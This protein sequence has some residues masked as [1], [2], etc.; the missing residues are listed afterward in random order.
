MSY[1]TTDT[2]TMKREIVNFSNKL[3]HDLPKPNKKFIADM[4]YGILASKS[5][6]LSDITDTLHEDIKKKNTIERLS[7][8]LANGTPDLLLDH[9]LT[10][11][12]KWI[13]D[14]PVIHID[15][16]DIV[17]PNEIGRAHV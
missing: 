4:T 15:D 8:H 9:Y 13:P 6:L 11:I 5:C 14:E 2:Y 1:F 3:S 16:S 17:K 10:Q 7:R 12:K